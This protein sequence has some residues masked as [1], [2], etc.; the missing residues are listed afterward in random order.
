LFNLNIKKQD[1]RLVSKNNGSKTN[2]SEP[3]LYVLFVDRRKLA[4]T[5]FL[6]CSCYARVSTSN[7]A[8]L[9]KEY[10]DTV[11]VHKTTKLMKNSALPLRP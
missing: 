10:T 5:F 9:Y 3:Y 4:R 2:M 6:F 11:Y 1:T 8:G 7:N